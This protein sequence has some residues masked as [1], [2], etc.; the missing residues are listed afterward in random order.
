MATVITVLNFDSK[1]RSTTIMVLK[2]KTPI[3]GAT[4]NK[5]KI[6]VR[7]RVVKDPDSRWVAYWMA[8]DGYDEGYLHEGRS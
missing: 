6:Y 8:P 2:K 1:G 7:D 3:P 5:R 4:Y